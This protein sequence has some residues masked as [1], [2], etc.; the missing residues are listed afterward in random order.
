MHLNFLN[1]TLCPSPPKPQFGP[2]EKILA[3]LSGKNKEKWTH[4]HFFKGILGPKGGPKRVIFGHKKF[5]S[6][7]SCP[8]MI[9]SNHIDKLGFQT[10]NEPEL[11]RLLLQPYIGRKRVIMKYRHIQNYHLSNSKINKTLAVTVILR[12]LI[13]MTF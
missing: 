3:S 10:E 7:F 4:I 1:I 8:L 2:P 6:L 12:K 9:H 11:K 13:Q 5:S